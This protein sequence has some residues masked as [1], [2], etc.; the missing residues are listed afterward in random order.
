MPHLKVLKLS[1][2]RGAY[3]RKCESCV[4]YQVTIIGIYSF[5]FNPVQSSFALLIETSR[6]SYIA[7]QMTVSYMDSNTEVK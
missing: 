7:N 3:P 5:V 6:L 2:H 4:S 1:E